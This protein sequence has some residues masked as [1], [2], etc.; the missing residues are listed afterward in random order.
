MVAQP[1]LTEKQWC[2]LDSLADGRQPFEQVYADNA[3]LSPWTTP[4]ELRS[5]LAYLQAAGLVAVGET[6][7][8][9]DDGQAALPDSGIEMTPQGAAEWDDPRYEPYWKES[10]PPP[11][12]FT[13]PRRLQFVLAGLFLLL[14]VVGVW[15]FLHATWSIANDEAVD[16]SQCVRPIRA[17]L[18]AAGAPADVLAQLD[19]AGQAGIWRSE[20]VA[21]LQ[22]VD[23]SLS[24]VRASWV[25]SGAQADVRGL[26]NDC[27]PDSP[28][29]C[30]A[31]A[32]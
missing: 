3:A 5:E 2:I 22:A 1:M 29:Q 28:C 20:A 6:S 21:R 13:F 8:P 25:L 24:S 18:A 14:A 19:K 23:A 32:K 10:P 26:M 12:Q 17:K 15:A 4:E 30:G 16:L 9:P 11:K 31:P 27:R 7:A